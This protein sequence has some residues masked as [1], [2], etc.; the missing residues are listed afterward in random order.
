[1]L[2]EEC[3]VELIRKKINIFFYDCCLFY[4]KLRENSF[5]D[6]EYF[7][8]T[9]NSVFIGPDMEVVAEKKLMKHLEKQR[10]V[11]IIC[12]MKLSLLIPPGHQNMT[13][14]KEIVWDKKNG[15]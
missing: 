15:T 10:S 14:G 7:V 8:W 12:L 6:E 11:L 13:K 1:M 5:G 4:L 2:K 3:Q 9:E